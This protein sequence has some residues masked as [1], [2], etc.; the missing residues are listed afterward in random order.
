MPFWII[1]HPPVNIFRYRRLYCFTNVNA[2]A[3]FSS[4]RAAVCSSLTIKLLT[5][6]MA[7]STLPSTVMPGPAIIVESNLSNFSEA[8]FSFSCSMP[9]FTMLH[10]GIAVQCLFVGIEFKERCFLRF[11]DIFYRFVVDL[12]D[13][14]F[15][16]QGSQS[17]GG[18]FAQCEQ[19][20]A[21]AVCQGQFFFRTF[22]TGHIAQSFQYGTFGCHIAA[23]HPCGSHLPGKTS[24]RLCLY[25]LGWTP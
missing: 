5:L 10:P 22:I 19:G 1:R 24:V 14:P 2:S 11:F 18:T 16:V 6:F 12:R 3:P 23:K 13:I 7:S 17:G 8:G 21:V 15:A 20:V 25:P 4:N 9:P